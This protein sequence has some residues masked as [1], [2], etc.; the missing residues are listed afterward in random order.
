MWIVTSRTAAKHILL[1]TLHIPLVFSAL[2]PRYP[3]ADSISA[4]DAL[5]LITVDAAHPA[6]VCG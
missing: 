1:F 6:R 5:L 2:N 3:F 4:L